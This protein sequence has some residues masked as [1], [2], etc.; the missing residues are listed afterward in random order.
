MKFEDAAG[1]SVVVDT[2]PTQS[3]AKYCLPYV[4]FG[5]TN[6]QS[7]KVADF[8]K[9]FEGTQDLG[10][11]KPPTKVT[12]LL[13]VFS[14]K[15]LHGN[16]GSFHIPTED[17]GKPGVRVP[18][19]HYFVECPNTGTRI[20]IGQQTG[21]TWADGNIKLSGM[22]LGEANLSMSVA[23]KDTKKDGSANPFAMKMVLVPNKRAVEL[24]NEQQSRPTSSNSGPEIPVGPVGPRAPVT[25]DTEEL[26]EGEIK[27]EEDIPF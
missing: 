2:T 8:C 23:T 19:V 4:F 13:A 3:K 25:P 15:D 6:V 5:P 12:K 21:G 20:W 27:N 7:I 1:T 17:L 22:V 10:N 9:T 11:R 18:F 24:W 14:N 16:P 26:A